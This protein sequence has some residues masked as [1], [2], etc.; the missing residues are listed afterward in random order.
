[1]VSERSQELV[2]SLV[3]RAGGVREAG[4]RPQGLMWAE[5][6]ALGRAGVLRAQTPQRRSQGQGKG[7]EL[8]LCSCDKMH[9]SVGIFWGD[10]QLSSS[11][12]DSDL[13]RVSTLL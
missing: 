13:R 1:M 10:P 6:R 9:L 3:K 4:L 5:G 2:K 7:R 8:C 11:Y 12:G